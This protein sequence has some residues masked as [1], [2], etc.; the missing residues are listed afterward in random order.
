V[1]RWSV[2][3]AA[4]QRDS[5]A[6]HDALDQ[7][8][9]LYWRPIYLFVRRRG[10]PPE[11]ARDL[12]Q[13]FF[14][15]LL[16]KDF[17]AGLAPSKGRFRTFLLAALKHYL[18]NEWDKGRCQK[19]GG[20]QVLIPLEVGAEDGSAGLEPVDHQTAEVNFDRDWAL[21]L[22][23][24]VLGRLRQEYARD[25]KGDLFEGLK[26]TLVEG[27]SGLPYAVIARGL[28]LSEGAVKVAVHRLRQRFRQLLREEIAHTL[29]RPEHTEEELRA[30]FAALS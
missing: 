6:G 12:T 14:A 13:G 3:L 29:S 18:A 5:Q 19:R 20:G 9:R 23:G 4:G 28:G 15:G 30:L 16:A 2:V 21:A 24:Q 7:L 25:G 10:H 8:C 1:T 17:L 27:G 11:D 26:A 22:L